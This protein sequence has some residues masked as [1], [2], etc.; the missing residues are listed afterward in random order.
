MEA[1]D[2]NDEIAHREFWWPTRRDEQHAKSLAIRLGLCFGSADRCT[3]SPDARA[4][5][6]REKAGLISGTAENLNEFFKC[7]SPTGKK[8]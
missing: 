3:S 1:R 5:Y 4:F 7:F 2:E 8:D 6:N